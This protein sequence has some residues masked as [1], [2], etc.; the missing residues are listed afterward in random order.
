MNPCIKC[1]STDR[2][3]SGHCR[4]CAIAW[5]RKK[6][7]E[8]PEDVKAQQAKYVTANYEKVRESARASQSRIRKEN[9]ERARAKDKLDRLA[10]PEQKL[11]ST[12]AWRAKNPERVKELKARH[13][14]KNKTKILAYTA[15]YREKNTDK[16][17]KYNSGWTKKRRSSEPEKF[18]EARRIIW[19]NR[20]ARKMAVGGK[21]S[22]GLSAKLFR[23]QK[24]KCACCGS[25]LGS[26][27]HMDHIMPL[28]LGGP[29]T[30]CN[31]QLLTASCNKSK[32][33]KNPID[34]MQSRG[35]LI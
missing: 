26:D 32:S 15:A 23:L 27:F 14:E 1:G 18:K 31:I 20:R 28:A 22:K 19:N 13:Y 34:F 30:D 35:F 11:L 9:P 2:Y 3:K 7:L 12:A 33:A 4:P 6:R 24:G 16:I 29:N 25:P 17:K 10:N 8:R 21:L 5:N